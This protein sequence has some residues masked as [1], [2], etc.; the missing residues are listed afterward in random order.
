M[1]I[2]TGHALHQLPQGLIVALRVT[3]VLCSLSRLAGLA[4]RTNVE[5][6]LAEG[7]AERRLVQ[8]ELRKI[9]EAPDE[10]RTSKR[11]ARSRNLIQLSMSTAMGCVGGQAVEKRSAMRARRA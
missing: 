11:V 1:E 3:S 2:L 7:G 6:E 9:S 10:R 8:E 4:D 5:V